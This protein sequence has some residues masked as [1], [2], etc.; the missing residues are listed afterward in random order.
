[1]VSK[2][3]S[4]REVRP[5]RAGIG[6]VAWLAGVPRKTISQAIEGAPQAR[7]EARRQI[8]DFLKLAGEGPG[9]RP[10]PPLPARPRL[11]GLIYDAPNP[12]RVVG[13]QDGMME[14]LAEL[15]VELAIRRV[16]AESPTLFAQVRSFVLGQKL[17]GVAVASP[18]S[19][20]ERLVASIQ[21]LGVRYAAIAPSPARAARK[22]GR[23]AGE[24]LLARRNG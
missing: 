24:R 7:A 9:A 17:E 5:A 14:A 20:D 16:D 23:V 2:G 11:I 22:E 15:G 10:R 21:A 13:W 6:D 3:G 19:Q 18:L 12:E 1:V 8:L 4:G